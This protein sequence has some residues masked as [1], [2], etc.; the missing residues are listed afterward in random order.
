MTANSTYTCTR[1]NRSHTPNNN[2]NNR[3]L[4]RRKH[5]KTQEKYGG[6]YGKIS[7]TQKY[8]VVFRNGNNKRSGNDRSCKHSQSQITAQVKE[9]LAHVNDTDAKVCHNLR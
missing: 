2:N 6:K 7:R 3:N 1:E 9:A 5:K 8:E 4:E